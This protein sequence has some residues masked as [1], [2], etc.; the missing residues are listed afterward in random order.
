METICKLE[1]SENSG[2]GGSPVG[3]MSELN[4]LEAMA[5]IYWR[6]WHDGKKNQTKM[7][8]E[9]RISLGYYEG[10]KLAKS[11]EK[12]CSLILEK[13]RR[14][15]IRHDIGCKCVG[16]DENCFSKFIATSALF[17][18]ED[19]MMLACL[20]VTPDIAPI[21]TSLAKDVGLAIKGIV[22]KSDSE[23][24]FKFPYANGKMKI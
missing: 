5:I 22:S 16:I 20:F 4:D 6:L 18:K 7:L 14:S 23:E 12:L 21:L 13:G 24:W 1:M 17:E 3:L 15:F 9:L 11:F 2:F 10:Y 19:A 8:R